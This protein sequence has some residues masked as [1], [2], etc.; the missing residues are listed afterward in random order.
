MNIDHM[1]SN[2]RNAAKH[3]GDNLVQQS[4]KINADIERTYV[5]ELLEYIDTAK[6]EAADI[7]LTEKFHEELECIVIAHGLQMTNIMLTPLMMKWIIL[8]H[9]RSKKITG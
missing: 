1:I 9:E 7:V 2:A 6:E 8:A 5:D 3:Y 4:A